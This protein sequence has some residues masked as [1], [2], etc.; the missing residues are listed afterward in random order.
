[1]AH[2]TL[3]TI[4]VLFQY[5]IVHRTG[6]CFWLVF[7]QTGQTYRTAMP[8]LHALVTRGRIVNTYIIYST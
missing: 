8:L 4:F 7:V 3:K 2:S 6:L 5:F 1:L